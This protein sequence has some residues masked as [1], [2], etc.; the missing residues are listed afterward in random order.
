M[1]G[2]RTQTVVESCIDKTQ[3]NGLT[4]LYK[5]GYLFVILNKWAKFDDYLH[6]RSY[7]SKADRRANERT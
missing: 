1:Y 3:T 7:S 2:E 5:P 6:F 4:H